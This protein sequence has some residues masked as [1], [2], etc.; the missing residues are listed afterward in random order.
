[1][2]EYEL[3]GYHPKVGELMDE[4]GVSLPK[5]IKPTLLKKLRFLR[6]LAISRG[7]FRDFAESPYKFIFCRSDEIYQTLVNMGHGNIALTFVDDQTGEVFFLLFKDK[8]PEDFYPMPVTHESTEYDERKKET[9]KPTAHETASRKEIET[10]E[11]LGRKGDY[12]QFL[13]E[14]YPGHYRQLREM[15]LIET[16][17]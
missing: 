6:Q 10:A 7:D 13:K 8:V 11:R 5:E 12:L 14:N 16:K 9:D 15:G 4:I 3:E 1:M 2:V 17:R